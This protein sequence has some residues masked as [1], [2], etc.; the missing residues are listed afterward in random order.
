MI[1]FLKKYC[2]VIS[3]MI[4]LILVKVIWVKCSTWNLGTIE[5]EKEDILQRK[6]WLVDKVCIEPLQLLKEM[7]GGIGLQFQGEWALYTCSM[8]TKALS[9][10]AILYPETKDESIATIDSLIEI[11]K[12]PELRYYDRVRWYEDPLE[13]LEGEKSHVSYLSHL[14]WMVGNYKKIGGDNKHDDI[15]DSICE[16]M[17]RRIINSGC[18]NLP[19]YPGEPIYIPDMLV[20]IVALKEYSDLNNGRYLPTV[21][22]WLEEASKKWIDKETGLLSSF[23]TEEGEQTDEIKGSYSALNCY[24]LTLIDSDFAEQQYV[25]LKDKFKQ[26]FPYHGLKEYHDHSC[27]I[28][29][30]MDAGPIICNLSPSG[31]AFTIG[32]ATYFNDIDYRKGLLKT[33]EIAAHTVKWGDK[34]HYL[35]GNIALVGEAI[36]LAMRTNYS[37]P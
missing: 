16:T 13:S 8:L 36:T 22:M 23:I 6:N 14:A 2:I 33:A 32:S 26:K 7:P 28:G 4:F 12:S 19:T 5:S 24:Y 10:I 31:T 17:N 1:Q 30:D 29:L 27:W 15:Y 37:N 25:R 34:R 9:N 3:V 18:L 20:A 35:L 11:V 21:R